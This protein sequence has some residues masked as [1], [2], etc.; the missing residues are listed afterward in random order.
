MSAPPDILVRIVERRRRSFGVGAGEGP[1]KEEKAGVLG[2]D[3]AFLAALAARRSRAVIAE[4]KMG[5]PRLGR[6]AGRVDP[7]A[8]AETY[9]RAGAAALSVVVEPDFFGGSYELLAACRRASG[10]P[11]LAK[12]FVVSLRQLE[13]ARRAGAD[14]VLLIAALYDADELAGWAD[15]ARCAGLA[16]LVEIHDRADVAKLAGR[17]WELVGVNNRDLRTFEVDLERSL[18]VLPRLP[19]AALKVAES[20]ISAAAEVRRLAAAGFD[21]FL[22]GES[23]LLADDP[24]ARLASLLERPAA[25]EPA[26]VKICGVTRIEDAELAVELGADFL[27]LN[28]YPASP[29]YV[30]PLQ[31]GRIASAV[32]DRVRL[33]GVVVNPN[34]REVEAVLPLVDLIQ[35]HGEE[36]PE[37]VRPWAERAIKVLRPEDHGPGLVEPW[38]GVWGFLLEP[39]HPGLRG[40]TGET[41]D[42]AAAPRLATD[43]PVFLA[44]G[45]APDNVRRA[46]A[47][48]WGIDVCSGVESKPGVKDPAKLRR[49]FSE[50]R[51]APL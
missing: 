13:R 9:A 41:W 34:L 38:Q 32:G 21:A 44:G 26:R 12:D 36:G 15:L 50:L 24:V 5:S 43:R 17:E 31:A 25:A 48:A 20:G 28:F 35:F 39:R 7:R 16:P 8:Q 6:L 19:A 27:G 2:P 14:A 30:E 47:G 45:I 3:Q 46:A 42:Y 18:E 4:V 29:R 49:L 23:L 11:A 22:I 1:P 33:V 51:D 40:G 37:T 10:L